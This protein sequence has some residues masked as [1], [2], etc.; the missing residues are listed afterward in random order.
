[1]SNPYEQPY[2]EGVYEKFTI[3]VTLDKETGSYMVRCP[4]WQC[5]F[6]GGEWPGQHVHKL[7]DEIA[8]H[9]KAEGRVE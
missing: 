6:A 3:E 2:P 1:M 8:A 7:V 4:E 5:E 9:N